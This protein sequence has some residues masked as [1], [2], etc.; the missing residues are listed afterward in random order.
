MRTD[1]D[2]RP[3]LA[4]RSTDPGIDGDLPPE[5]DQAILDRVGFPFEKIEERCAADTFDEAGP[6][7]PS[8][9]TATA[10]AA[11]RRTDWPKVPGYEI[12]E[13]LGEGG[14]GV[15]YGARQVGLNRR[16]ALKM[17][18]GGAQARLESVARFRIEAE[19]VARLRHPHILQ[20][21]DIGEVEGSPFVSLE[22]LE[23][24]TLADRL[25]ATPQPGRPAAELVATLALAIDHA[26]RSGIIHRDLKPTNVLFTVDGTPKIADFGLAKRIDA[27][28]HPT[29]SGQIM[30][31]PS[32]MAPEQA[33]GHS[34]DIGP[35]ADVYA[36][37]AILY[38]MLTGRPPFK[39]E[40]AFE[41]I[42]QLSDDD[43]VPPSRL[44][45]RVTRDLETICLKCLNKDPARRYASAQALADDL[46]RYT[47][48]EPI[49]ARP[50]P[51]WER[52]SKWARRHPMRAAAAILLA[53][54]TLGMIAAVRRDGQII[55]ARQTAGLSL[56]LTADAARSPDELEQAQLKLA[57]FVPVIKNE[58]RLKFLANE[59]ALKQARISRALDDLKAEQEKR[60][61]LQAERE[62]LQKFRSL[63]NETQLYAAHLMVLD[64]AEHKKALRAKTSAA[65]EV[66]GQAD[67]APATTWS[68]ALPSS[69][70][71][72]AALVAE[73]K[74]SCYDLL[75]ILA[76]AEEPAEGLK[77]LDRAVGLRPATTTAYHRARAL[78]LGRMNDKSGQAREE[79]LARD[80]KPARAFDHLL[81]GASSSRLT[82]N[83]RRFARQK[84]RCGST[85]VSSV[86]TF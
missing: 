73:V 61:Q 55:V 24:G 11:V 81:I 34:R 68:L 5:L 21:F 57:E 14:M 2:R 66:Y 13:R 10:A 46:G 71:L 79:Q 85:R 65:L 30:G 58:P 18:R 35:A 8:D 44:V 19:A 84:P 36:L 67:K 26:H 50:T 64:P 9:G 54:L 47:R 32:Y 75:L 6:E 15:V 53:L 17:I 40:T 52:R 29:E 1:P 60:D 48:G 49:K 3:D 86:L 12:T 74:E 7:R 16:V 80:T 28:E 38:E 76:E 39:G 43:P 22:L 27:A 42:R 41:T 82:R 83:A 33:W 56:L 72:S 51:F 23:G 62:R 20:I 63:R 78:C 59:I 25:A 31:S 70:A 45:P 4:A 77:I 37:G 69:S